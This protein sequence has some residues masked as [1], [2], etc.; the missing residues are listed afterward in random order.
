MTD[1]E[2]LKILNNKEVENYRKEQ[3]KIKRENEKKAKE[4]KER[5]EKL[6]R[7]AVKYLLKSY[8]Y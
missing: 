8:D 4:L 5:I 2:T 7:F 3:R 1:I 6:S